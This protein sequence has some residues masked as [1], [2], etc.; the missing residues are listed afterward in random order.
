MKQTERRL[1]DQGIAVFWVKG[2][3]EAFAAEGLDPDELLR[4]A[5]IEPA[6][7]ADA[8]GRVPTDAV[9]RLWD[10]AVT[11]SGSPLIGLRACLQPRPASF[12]IVAYAMMTARDLGGLLDRIQ[13]YVRLINDTARVSLV[14][15]DRGIRLVLTASNG[16]YPWQEIAF[17]QLTFLSFCRWVMLR[18]LR[19][20]SLELAFPT[21]R[22]HL[23]GLDV[24]AFPWRFDA[25]ENALVFSEADLSLPLPTAHP[26]MAELAERVVRERL[27]TLHEGALSQRVRALIGER[28]SEG[29]PSRVSIAAELGASPRTLHRRLAEEGSS[30]R[31]IMDETR[32]DLAQALIE[33]PEVSLADAAFLLGFRDQS[34]FFRAYRRWF[35]R[36]PRGDRR[37]SGE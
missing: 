8:D 31:E 18:D 3:V 21:P 10:A 24:F 6:A 15:D 34:G 16:A 4:A 20:V 14:R 7:L 9:S 33:R 25:L 29:E 36:S 35:G 23:I 26:Q 17:A 13:R 37:H 30:F 5:R 27:R 19:P 2:T 1:G 11:R 12:G 22:A 28:L 32:R